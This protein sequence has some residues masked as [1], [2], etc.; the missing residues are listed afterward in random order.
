MYIGRNLENLKKIGGIAL[1]S[2]QIRP[3]YELDQKLKKARLLVI[4]LDSDPTGAVQ[5]CRWWLKNYHNAIWWPI[6][7]QC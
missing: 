5:T 1:G 6:Q 2:A 7:V 4:A 3:D